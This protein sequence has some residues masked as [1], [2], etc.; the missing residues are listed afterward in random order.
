M[1]ERWVVVSSQKLNES[2]S[3]HILGRPFVIEFR[4]PSRILYDKLEFQTVQQASDDAV[5][6][7]FD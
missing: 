7:Q 2:S 5:D 6:F 3:I 4:Q 1:F